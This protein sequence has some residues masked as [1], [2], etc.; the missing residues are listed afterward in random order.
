MNVIE[1]VR[2]ADDGVGVRILDQRELPG[3]EVYRELRTVE[4]AFEAIQT[5]AVRGAPAIGITAA[6][7]TTLAIGESDGNVNVAKRGL[8]DACD[9]LNASRPTAVNLHWAVERMRRA[10]DA[11]AGDMR[12]L[13]NALH[14]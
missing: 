6:M 10:S 8:A 11:H 5:L 12:S 7:A 1:P 14:N 9:R 2:W 3:R 4:D 13:R